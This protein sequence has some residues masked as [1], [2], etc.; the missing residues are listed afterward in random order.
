MV[1][2]F[3]TDDG[4]LHVFPDAAVAIGYCEGFD[5]ANGGW[6]FFSADGTALEAVFSEPARKF[7]FTVSHGVYELRP[8]SGATLRDRFAD[9]RAVEGPPEQRSLEQVGAAL[10]RAA[11]SQRS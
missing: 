10:V 9:I 4:A 8:G 11:S 2:A 1:Y 6:Q 7:A 5:V 3:S